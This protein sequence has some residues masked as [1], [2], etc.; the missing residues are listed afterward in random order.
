MSHRL[1]NCLRNS[2][3]KLNELL[4]RHWIDLLDGSFDE[5]HLG[6]VLPDL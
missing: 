3:V 6:A 2:I 1:I 4:N 5:S